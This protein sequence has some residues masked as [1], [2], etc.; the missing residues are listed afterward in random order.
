M[1]FDLIYFIWK[2]SSFNKYKA[3]EKNTKNVGEMHV[4]FCY[5]FVYRCFCIEFSVIIIIIIIRVQCSF[6]FIKAI[7]RI[8]S[9][10]LEAK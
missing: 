3:T 7:I 8:F 9:K 10:Y 5:T 1:N 4:I 6:K 2:N